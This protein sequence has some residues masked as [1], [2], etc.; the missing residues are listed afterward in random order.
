MAHHTGWYHVEETGRDLRTEQ[1]P[2][3]I[4]NEIWTAAQH[5]APNATTIETFTT[6]RPA[7]ILLVATVA[8]VSQR[9]G[10]PVGKNAWLPLGGPWHAGHAAVVVRV[11]PAISSGAFPFSPRAH[12]SRGP[13]RGGPT[14]V[15]VSGAP[16]NRPR[17]RHYRVGVLEWSSTAHDEMTACPRPG[18]VI[19]PHG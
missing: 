4:G 13:W 9:H 7:P 11:I 10:R 2:G 18:V 5:P 16:H 1:D 15:G 3:S 19:L 8:A 12:V 17:R 6:S 14:S